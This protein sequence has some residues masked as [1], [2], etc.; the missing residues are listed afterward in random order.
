MDKLKKNGE[1][2]GFIEFYRKNIDIKTKIAKFT[3]LY[4]VICSNNLL[5]KS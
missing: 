1:R 3:L 4:S 2:M 5:I